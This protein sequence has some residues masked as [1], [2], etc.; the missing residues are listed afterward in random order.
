MAGLEQAG[1]KNCISR[2]GARHLMEAMHGVKPLGK[3]SVWLTLEA[4]LVCC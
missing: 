2:A 1:S 4:E 3:L